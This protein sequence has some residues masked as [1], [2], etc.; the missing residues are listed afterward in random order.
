[1]VERHRHPLRMAPAP[2]PDG[3]TAFSHSLY[4]CI[5]IPIIAAVDINKASGTS[6]TMASVFMPRLMRIGAGASR[7]L[8]EALLSIGCQRPLI[9][10]DKFMSTS[11]LL[12]PLKE[13][14][15]ASG[16][17]A[18]VFDGVVPDP[19]TTSLDAGIAMATASACDAVVG[20]GGGSSIDSAKAIACLAVHQGPLARFKAPAEAP[21]GLPVIAIP[22]TAGTGSEVTKVLI[23]TDCSTDEKM[24]V[25]GSGLL[26]SVALVDYELTMKKPYRLTADNGLDA[27]CHALEAYVSRK[28]T[29]FTDTLALGACRTIVRHLRTACATPSDRNAREALMLAATQ[30][31]I[32]FSNASVT[33]IHGMSRPVG[34]RFHVPHGL[35]NALL[36]PKLTAFSLEGAPERYADA[37][38]ASGFADDSDS[39]VAACNKLV[40]GLYALC[41]DVEVP[42]LSELGVSRADFVAAAP[43]MAEHA[44]ASGSPNNNPIVPS[45]EAIQGLYEEVYA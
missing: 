26:P 2:P 13:S 12:D 11:G 30:A 45:A 23:V 25:M 32:A 3:R 41:S 7:G 39:D 44:L 43:I 19:T 16:I 17:H 1:M 8:S 18:V 4:S 21:A 40:D 5:I 28:A 42:T 37:S 10:T 15:D 35:S 31:G 36:L 14:L 38:R 29:P 24:L 6:W 22:T 33:L 20:F 34:A 9:V 27:Y